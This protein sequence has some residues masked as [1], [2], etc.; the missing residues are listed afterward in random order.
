MKKI[1]SIFAVVCLSII[2]APTA[3]ANCVAIPAGCGTSV[4]GEALCTGTGETCGIKT[5][6]TTCSCYVPVTPTPTATNKV[7]GPSNCVKIRSTFTMNLT[8]ASNADVPTVLHSGAVVAPKGVKTSECS[9][10]ESDLADSTN[11]GNDI[12]TPCVLYKPSEIGIVA[13]LNTI[14]N[15][16]NWVFFLLTIL[17][18][19]MIIYG[20]FIYITAAGDPAKATKA[21]G[22]LTFAVI[23]LAIAL[24]A[25]FLPSLV[26]FILGVK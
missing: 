12:T 15:V 22:I 11:C 25:K 9:Y 17:A 26:K 20:G 1:L 21:K 10:I 3:F 19:L 13:M 4:S 23:G 8:G 16:T 5:G 24:I 7:F 18:V 6:E 14:Y 2:F